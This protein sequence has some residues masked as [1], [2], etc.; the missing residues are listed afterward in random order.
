MAE[1]YLVRHGQASFGSSNYDQLSELGQQQAVWLGEYF[2]ERNIHFDRLITGTQL[3]HRQTLEGITKGFNQSKSTGDELA[4]S[5]E[6]HPGFNEYDFY[7]LFASLG[8]KHLQLKTYAMGDKRSFYKGLKE[9]LK[10]W[11]A[12][13]LDGPLP[14]RWAD[15]Y[16]R[17]GDAMKFATQTHA[18]K[19]LVVSSGGP[20]GTIAS[21]AMLSPPEIGMELNLQVRNSSFCHYFFNQSSLRLGSFNSIPHL[22]LPQRLNAITYG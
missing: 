21:Q 4:L 9:V 17:V 14:E 20:I 15:F 1:L 13:E 22:D 19:V 2:A 11:M 12:D 6:S 16:Q 5:S 10:L 3:R 7:A 8:D 18:E